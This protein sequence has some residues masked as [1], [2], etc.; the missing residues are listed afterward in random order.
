ML[1]MVAEHLASLLDGIMMMCFL[2]F[3]LQWKEE[4]KKYTVIF[5]ILQYIGAQY[6]MEQPVLQTVLMIIVNILYC[7]VCLKNTYTVQ[8]IWSMGLMI[9]YIITNGLIFP[10]LSFVLQM[11]ISVLIE[12]GQVIRIFALIIC[13]LLQCTIFWLILLKRKT[14][15]LLK[16]LEW[17]LVFLI[18][19]SN[20]FIFVG[21]L[22]VNINMEIAGEEQIRLIAIFLFIL[23]VFFCC[24]FLVIHI[25][26]INAEAVSS[27]MLQVQL[28]NQKIM[29]E[30]AHEMQKE[31]QIIRHDLKHYAGVWLNQIQSGRVDDAEKEME[32]FIGKVSSLSSPVYYIKNNELI[33]SVLFDK[34]QSCIEK[35]ILCRCEI[36]T[37]FQKQREMDIAIILS[38]LL[39]NAIQAEESIDSEK[40]RIHIQMFQT[41]EKNHIIISNY[42]ENSVLQCNPLL[43]TTKKDKEKHGLG[44]MSVHKIVEKYDGFINIEEEEHL[45]IV[46]ISSI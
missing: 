21:L 38:N 33:N 23:V 39:E 24:I 27:N 42:I 30:K 35:G 1:Y 17:F 5:V 44:V 20:I 32:A 16:P 26:R 2:G 29:I 4:R 10:M 9:P 19:I 3:M 6:F 11:P 46:H 13:K 45:F 7:K 25:S 34:I 36:T 28:E 43:K 18:L 41:H 12:A 14:V 31:T 15:L 40:R 37:S 22:I 8:F